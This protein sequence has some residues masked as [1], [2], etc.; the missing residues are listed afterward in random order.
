MFHANVVER[1]KTHFVLNNFICKNQAFYEIMWKNVAQP[2]R[3]QM[4]IKY[5]AC[6]LHAE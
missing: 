5:G 2:D 1:I 6:A 3:S 4:A